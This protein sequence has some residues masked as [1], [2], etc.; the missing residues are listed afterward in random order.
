MLRFVGCVELIRMVI[1][2]NLQLLLGS[3]VVKEWWGSQWI[4][5][6]AN[7]RKCRVCGLRKVGSGILLKKICVGEQ[8]NSWSGAAARR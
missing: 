8:G 3:F 7:G 5:N 1:H 4:E 2:P 6:S